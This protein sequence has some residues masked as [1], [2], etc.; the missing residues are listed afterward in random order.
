M[1]R[2]LP[3]KNPKE[4]QES[5]LTFLYFNSYKQESTT[6]LPKKKNK[7]VLQERGKVGMFVTFKFVRTLHG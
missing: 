2:N 6:T 7:R 3:P 5:F 4:T 1:L